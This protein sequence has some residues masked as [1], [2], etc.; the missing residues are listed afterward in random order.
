MSREITPER[1]KG[2]SQSKNNTQVWMWLVIEARTD[3]VKSNIAQEPGMLGPWI[4][5]NWKWSNRWWQE[6]NW[7][8]RNQQTKMD[9]NG[10]IQL[11]WPLYL[12]LQAGIP[13]KKWRSHHGQQKSLKCSTWMQAQKRQNDLCLF[14]RQTIQYYNDPSLP[15]PIMMKKLKW[16]GSMKTSKTF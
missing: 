5:A 7:H 3:A 10:W 4:K 6:W 1:M 12:L 14:P 16:N 13:E 2:W 11:R 9:W 15:Q 8:S